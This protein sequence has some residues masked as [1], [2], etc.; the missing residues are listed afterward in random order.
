M[1]KYRPWHP[2]KVLKNTQTVK[3]D[4]EVREMDVRNLQAL[5]A[6]EATK[7]QQQAAL[8]AIYHICGTND[9]EFLP[10]EHG[11]ARDG[12]FKSGKRHVGMQLL[13]LISNPLNL[14]TG[15]K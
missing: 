1:S 6:G 11:G 9:L 2:V 7:G 3:T 15:E 13:K 10:D 14:Q 12:A 8:V 5:A 4:C